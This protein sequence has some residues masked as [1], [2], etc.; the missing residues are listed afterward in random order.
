[1]DTARWHHD[2]SLLALNLSVDSALRASIIRDNF[3]SGTARKRPRRI[4][5]VRR[6]A[7]LGGASQVLPKRIR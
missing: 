6:E 2:T 4:R 5:Q 1:M 7:A 3:P